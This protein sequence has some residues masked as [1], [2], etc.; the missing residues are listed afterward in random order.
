VHWTNIQ[1][2]ARNKQLLSNQP[3]SITKNVLQW[4]DIGEKRWQAC[5]CCQTLIF[6]FGCSIDAVK[7]QMALNFELVV[8]NQLFSVLLAAYKWFKISAPGVVR[9]HMWQ[10]DWKWQWKLYPKWKLQSKV[11]QISAKGAYFNNIDKILAWNL[12]L[13]IGLFCM[14]TFDPNINKLFFHCIIKLLMKHEICSLYTFEVSGL[15]NLLWTKYQ[16]LA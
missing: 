4:N 8:S 5:S 3:F 10:L 2:F 16:L 1:E 9:R 14:L 7:Q 12:Q 15:R 11:C 13:K 6:Q